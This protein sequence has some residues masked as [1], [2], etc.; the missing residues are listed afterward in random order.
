MCHYRIYYYYYYYNPSNRGV[1]SCLFSIF[2]L[3]I[4]ISA[5]L[6]LSYRPSIFN[7]LIAYRMIRLINKRL[8]RN[9]EKVKKYQR[10]IREIIKK[11]EGSKLSQS[12]GIKAQSNC[13]FSSEYFIVG[14][15][16]ILKKHCS[17]DAFHLK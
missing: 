14:L 15:G 10:N 17:I 13:E 1:T 3:L 16:F 6:F 12:N 11:K 7:S 4:I 5:L 8:N 9:I 2:L